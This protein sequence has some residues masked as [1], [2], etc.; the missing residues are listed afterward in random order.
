[1]AGQSK[2]HEFIADMNDD[3]K[4][5]NLPNG[6]VTKRQAFLDDPKTVLQYYGIIIDISDEDIKSIRDILKKIPNIDKS[7]PDIAPVLSDLRAEKPPNFK[8]SDD[9]MIS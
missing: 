6:V 1:M 4:K 3:T 5:Y 7:P 2:Y 8:L 9:V